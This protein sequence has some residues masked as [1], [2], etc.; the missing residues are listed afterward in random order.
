MGGWRGAGSATS[1]CTHPSWKHHGKTLFGLR[2]GPV[3]CHCA[4]IHPGRCPRVKALCRVQLGKPLIGSCKPCEC[5]IAG[6]SSASFPVLFKVS[7]CWIRLHRCIILQS[8]RDIDEVCVAEEYM[9]NWMQ[10]TT[11]RL[12]TRS[13]PPRMRHDPSAENASQH[14]DLCAECHPGHM[15]FSRRASACS[16]S[17]QDTQGVHAAHFN[18]TQH[19]QTTTRPDQGKQ[20]DVCTLM[21]RLATRA[22]NVCGGPAEHTDAVCDAAATLPAICTG[23]ERWHA[24]RIG[25]RSRGLAAIC[26]ESVEQFARLLKSQHMGS[27]STRLDLWRSRSACLRPGPTSNNTTV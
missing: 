19:A 22:L 26:A 24:E 23:N 8:S 12:G 17:Q 10:N 13:I 2:P 3:V 20:N 9:V 1:Y 25:K 27:P 5:R 4:S 11:Q 7:S 21:T 18:T 16:T 15:N 14:I 6:C